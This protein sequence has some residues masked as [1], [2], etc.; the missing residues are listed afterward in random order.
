MFSPG[1]DAKISQ[2]YPQVLGGESN[3]MQKVFIVSKEMV[4]IGFTSDLKSPFLPI[5][6]TQHNF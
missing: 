3:S 2:L 1:T 5:L 4:L 6:A